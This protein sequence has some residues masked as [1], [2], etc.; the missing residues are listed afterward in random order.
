MGEGRGR[1]GARGHGVEML[2]GG[3]PLLLRLLSVVREEK[4]KREKKK[5]KEKKMENLL[6]LEISGEKNKR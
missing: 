1:G 6:N 4:E 3:Q 5:R 2:G